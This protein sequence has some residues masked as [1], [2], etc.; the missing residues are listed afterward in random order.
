MSLSRTQ[1]VGLNLQLDEGTIR[2]SLGWLLNAQ[3]CNCVS[4]LE[5]P[6]YTRAVAKVS[7]V[8]RMDTFL[9]IVG[10]KKKI[11]DYRLPCT[12][13]MRSGSSR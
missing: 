6:T 11:K 1:V 12:Q 2:F 9:L 13:R 8:A 4:P 3:V 5:H 7:T 10:R